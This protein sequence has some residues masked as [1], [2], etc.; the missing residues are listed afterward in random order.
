LLIFTQVHTKRKED[1]D[2]EALLK[3]FALTPVYSGDH[4]VGPMYGTIKVE[5]VVDGTVTKNEEFTET[6]MTYKVNVP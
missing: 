6:T 5:F 2:D 3:K 4:G 1:I